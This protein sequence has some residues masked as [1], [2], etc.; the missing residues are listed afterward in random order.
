[1]KKKQIIVSSILF[2]CGLIG[3]IMSLYYNGKDQF[4]YYT[5][6]SNYSL[7]IINGI[8]L[9]CLIFKDKVPNW[10]KKVLYIVSCLTSVT[11]IVVIFI[12]MP[13][14]KKV[15]WLLF[16]HELKFHHTLNP[17]LAVINLLLIKDLKIDKKDNILAVIPT[18]VYGTV[19]VI[20]N[21]LRLYEGPYGFLLVYKQP[22]YMS[23][24]WF[25]L[26]MSIAYFIAF[27][28]R[29]LVNRK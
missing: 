14:Y 24:I 9:F 25:I 28:L 23:V 7:F 2:I 26:I 21:L 11:F 3:L 8:Y 12:L 20:V 18:I 13:M 29:K 16:Y 6:L 15:L 27:M 10:V 5:Q 1:M 19:M 17:V 22:W 4:L